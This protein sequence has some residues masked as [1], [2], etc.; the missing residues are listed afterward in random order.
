MLRLTILCV[1]AGVSLTWLTLALASPWTDTQTTS[2]TIT[3]LSPEGRKVVVF[4]EGIGTKLTEGE[5]D[6]MKDCSDASNDPA[7]G[8]IKVALLE[9]DFVCTD[10]LRYSYRGGLVD[11]KGNWDP[12]T[13]GCGDTKHRLLQPI[14][15]LHSMLLDY[16]QAHPDV[17]FILIGHSLGGV[18]SLETSRLLPSS[19]AAVI[20]IDSPLNH[21]SRQN[22]IDFRRIVPALP[23]TINCQLRV[24]FSSPVT[25]ELTDVTK[26]NRQ[27]IRKEKEALVTAVQAHGVRV[28]TI[29]NEQDCVWYLTL[30]GLSRQRLR[31][32]LPGDWIDDRESMLIHNADRSNLYPLG[33]QGCDLSGQLVLILRLLCLFDPHGVARHDTGITKDIAEFTGP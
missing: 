23:R 18:I 33:T 16:Q 28:M 6:A 11:E 2:G 17:K 13:Y 30:C 1:L 27:A 15:H 24:F 25:R 31:V 7:F 20:T 3:A 21:A 19:I 12:H 29:G 14:S 32:T 26:D 10:F 5:I 8:D 9:I 4:L 22:L